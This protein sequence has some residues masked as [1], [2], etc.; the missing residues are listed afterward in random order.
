MAHGIWGDGD[1]SLN[2][3]KLNNVTVYGNGRFNDL[4]VVQPRRVT[5]NFR[6]S[7]GWQAAF[8]ATWDLR[9]DLNLN[10]GCQGNCSGSCM[11]GCQGGC[12]GSCHGSCQGSCFT[13]CSSSCSSCGGCDSR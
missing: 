13:G 4:S 7:N 8:S 6:D 5:L 11:G 12:G 1:L 2:N 3:A 10:F 9:G